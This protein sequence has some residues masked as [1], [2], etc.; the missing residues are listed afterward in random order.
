MNNKGLVSLLTPCYNAGHLIGRLLDSVL[1]Q[2]YPRVEMVVIDDGSSDCSA[3]IINSYVQKF[4]AR[5]YSLQYYYQPNSGQSVAIRNGLRIITGE[6]LAWPDSDD[7]YATSDAIAKMVENLDNLPRQ[8]AIVRSCQKVV[9]EAS[10]K[11]LRVQGI[12]NNEEQLFEP[13]LYGRAGFYWGAGA[14][15]LRTD[16]LRQTTDLDIYA[17]KDAGQNWQLLLPVFYSYKCYTIPEVL[18]T[19]VERENSHGRGAYKGYDQL[20]I[21]KSTYENTILGTLDRMLLIPTQQREYYKLD[22]QGMVAAERM[23]LAYKYC[24]YKDYIKE[25][26]WLK[27]YQ[28]NRLKTI[29]AIR[30]YAIKVRMVKILNLLLACY[31]KINAGRK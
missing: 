12:G 23:D 22:I 1:S 20:L 6:Y 21:R 14:Y 10:L 3:E 31:N 17:E 19:V 9:D 2:T 11:V 15:M 4:S 16:I 30:Y 29:D 8:Y 26:I 27:T 7:F 5:G 13:C 28:N 18:Y 24:K 25:Y